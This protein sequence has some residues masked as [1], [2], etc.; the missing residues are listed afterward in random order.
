MKYIPNAVSRKAASV[1]LKTQKNS[2]TLLFIGGVV[3]VVATTVLACKATLELEAV[4]NEAEKD[5]AACRE[6]LEDS[7]RDSYTQDKYDHDIR[8]ITIRS[9]GKTLKLYGPAVILGS[10][11]IAALTK[12]HN[13]LS[14]RNAAL[15]AAYATLE[16]AFNE[17][18]KRVTDELGADKDREFYFG[19]KDKVILSEDKN[20]PKKKTIKVAADEA[21][22]SKWFKKGNPN[23]EPTF[24]YNIVFLRGVQNMATDRLRAKGFL[25]LNDVYEHLG[26]ERTREG[27]VVGW[28][29]GNGDDYVDFGIFNPADAGRVHDFVLNGDE[30][31]MLDFNVDGNIYELVDSNKDNKD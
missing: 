26:F 30:E 12:S 25:L 29:L 15:T 1:A 19:T 4:M 20:G 27:L 22:Y 13:I 11:S 24:E 3:G 10:I 23:W 18:R 7:A 6:M 17:Y 2:P 9:A 31:I 28:R 5:K 16:K 14:K 8:Y 21:G